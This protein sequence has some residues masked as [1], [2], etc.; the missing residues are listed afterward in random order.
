MKNFVEIK[1][2]SELVVGS[3]WCFLWISR[4]QMGIEEVYV[5]LFYMSQ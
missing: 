5:S 2:K 3:E 4:S 1:P